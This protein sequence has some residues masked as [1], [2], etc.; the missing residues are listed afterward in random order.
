MQAWNNRCMAALVNSWIKD[1]GATP[2]RK[3]SPSGVE[4]HAVAAP[5]AAP[6]PAT[7]TLE[8]LASPAPEGA[9]PA[10]P[11]P[12]P[13]PPESAETVAPPAEVRLPYPFSVMDPA[14]VPDEVWQQARAAKRING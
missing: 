14:E 1:V 4:D 11:M 10:S 7:Q 2:R 3:L 12:D 13:L 6:E 9:G 8:P 5:L